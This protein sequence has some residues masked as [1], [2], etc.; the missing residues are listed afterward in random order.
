MAAQVIDIKCPNCGG[1]VDT[2][3]K[4]CKYCKQPVIISTFNSVHAMPMPTLN[5]Y[6]GA[7]KK[8]LDEHPDNV[9]INMSI[10]MCY[11]KLKM[12]DKAREAFEKAMENNFDNS[13][14][15]F[16]S[17]ICLLG[18]KKAF[19]ASK[20]TIDKILEY[21]NAAVMIEPKGIY[22]YLLAYVKYDYF[23]R[24]MLNAPAP[25]YEETL[26]MANQAGVSAFDIEQLYEILGVARPD[27]L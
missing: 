3:Q 5:K 17:A 21:V 14:T 18:G 23:K 10:G 24:K 20:P 22:Y 25:A 16:Y 8:M 2:G 19:A 9:E 12:H 1:A 4:T 13:E 7:Y 15:F 11:L 27:V 26:V 6:S